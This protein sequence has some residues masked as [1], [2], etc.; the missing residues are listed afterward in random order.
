[1]ACLLTEEKQERMRQGVKEL[2]E[3]I[4][5]RHKYYYTN[6]PNEI[7][8]MTPMELFDIGTLNIGEFYHN[9]IVLQMELDSPQLLSE[10]EYATYPIYDTIRY[11]SNA[12]QIPSSQ[13]SSF[14][15][16][17]GTEVIILKTI[18]D[19]EL[20]K[21]VDKA[22]HLCGYY[23]AYSENVKGDKRFISVTYE[24][25]FN[26]TV[27][28]FVFREKVLYHLSPLPYKRRILKNGLIP[29]S[30]N[31]IF[32]YPCRTYLFLGSIGKNEVKSWITIFKQ[33]NKKYGDKPYCLYTID[34]SKLPRNID[35]YSDPNLEDAIYTMDNI[36]PKAI[37]N[38]EIYE[39]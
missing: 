2:K 32:K 14:E 17:D 20:F 28:D 22:M 10:A 4:E 3:Y 26:E 8:V 11:V 35:F 36:T 1:M 7:K 34:V 16:S 27:N 18:N 29:K 9:P 39:N 21:D 5:G 33:K 30:G 23:K 15:K 24:P 37:I 19:E 6:S 38:V 13:F 12:L 31:S 25:K